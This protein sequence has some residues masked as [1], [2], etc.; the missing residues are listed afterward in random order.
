[1]R[2][3]TVIE[4]LGGGGAERVC[5][6]LA[7]AWVARGWDVT[8]LTVS[9]GTVTP[10]YVVDSSV[11]RR[12]LGGYQ[13]ADPK[14]LNTGSLAPMLRAL[15][16][17]ACFEIIWEMPLLARLRYAILATTPDVVIAHLNFTNVRVLAAMHQTG[18]PVI[19]Y[20]H[21]DVSQF[22][23]NSWQN[24]GEAL[25]RRASA[26]VA[27][28]RAIATW[29]AQRGA[30]A[31]AIPNMLHAPPAICLKR[32]GDRRRLVTLMRLSPEKRVDI[33][34][35]AFARLAVDFPDWDFDI[36]GDGPQRDEITE[37]IDELAP[38]R[39]RLQGF[40]DDP[41]GVL[42]G[43]DLFVSASWAE[44]FGN[45]IWE[46]L[47]CGVPVVVLECGAPVRSLVRDGV[48]GLIVDSHSPDALS[49][50]LASLMGNDA[51]REA[52]AARTRE[53]TERFSGESALQKWDELL[54]DV[55]SR[56][57]LASSGMSLTRN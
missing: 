37:L 44:G 32:I 35:R 10:A 16:G 51:A 57:A 13:N 9:Q 52:L 30:R 43:A 25:Y 1:M 36:Y 50:A 4:D 3:T 47:A 14:E 42:G 41:Y 38:G 23:T 34:V 12:D 18:V 26:V 19:A 11:R 28:H 2:I 39:A 22:S 21:T 45:A 15:H 27:P 33:L 56:R 48:D 54:E 31:Y 5:I 17:V 53:V 29:L 6:N 8:I 55:I 46:A 20:E 7:N 40:T 49:A 24:M